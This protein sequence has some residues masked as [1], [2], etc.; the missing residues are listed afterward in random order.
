MVYWV[1][2]LHLTMLPV[3][4]FSH[5]YDPWS[6]PV[7]SMHIAGV[8]KRLML[9]VCWWCLWLHVPLPCCLSTNT[10]PLLSLILSTSTKSKNYLVIWTDYPHGKHF[11]PP[12]WVLLLLLFPGWPPLITPYLYIHWEKFIPYPVYVLPHGPRWIL[13]Y[14]TDLYMDTPT[15]L[16]Y[17]FPTLT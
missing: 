1:H 13:M 4:R 16:G 9:L 2:F 8:V 7:V 5:M 17:V 3:L 15:F 12:S 10:P 11:I 14:L 6:F